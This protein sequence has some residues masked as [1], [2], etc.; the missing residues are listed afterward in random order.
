MHPTSRIAVENNIKYELIT[1]GLLIDRHIDTLMQC[2]PSAIRISIDARTKASYEAIRVGANF[3]KLRCNIELV[4]ARMQQTKQT[5]QL[6]APYLV[7]ADTLKELPDFGKNFY[8]NLHP[9]QVMGRPNVY[10]SRLKESESHC[11]LVA[12]FDFL[13]DLLC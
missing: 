13:H 7:I 5:I 12:I 8:Q 2:P 9:E 3:E 10:T 6:G 11:E 1:N 4:L